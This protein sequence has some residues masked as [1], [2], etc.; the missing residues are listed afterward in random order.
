MEMARNYD[1]LHLKIERNTEK[2]STRVDFSRWKSTQVD[3]SEARYSMF[4]GASADLVWRALP[5]HR[6]DVGQQLLF[7]ADY[8]GEAEQVRPLSA[9]ANAPDDLVTAY[10]EQQAIALG[11]VCDQQATE[12]GTVVLP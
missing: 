12:C 1:E 6:D 2:G 10:R 5:Q 7:P 11:D 8:I 3:F 9:I 4:I